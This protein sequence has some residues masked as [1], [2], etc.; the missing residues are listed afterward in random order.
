MRIREA[1]PAFLPS[2]FP[3][4]LLP[5]SDCLQKRLCT[6]SP[7]WGKHVWEEAPEV[8]QSRP[9]GRELMLTDIQASLS[10]ACHAASPSLSR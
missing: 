2:P 10:W 4:P 6:V 9:D 3:Y 8:T 7:A 5:L 1:L